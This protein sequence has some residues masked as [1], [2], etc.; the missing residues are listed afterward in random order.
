M[1]LTSIPPRRIAL[2]ADCVLYMFL[3]IV[4][5]CILRLLQGRPV[6]HRWGKRTV[7]IA[8]IPYVHQILETFVSKMYSLSFGIASVGE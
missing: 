4:Y 1:P 8:D 7:V 2:V 6:W 3:P 5:A